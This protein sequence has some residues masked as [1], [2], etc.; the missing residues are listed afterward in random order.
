MLTSSQGRILT[1]G[2]LLQDSIHRRLSRATWLL[3][4]LAPQQ[5]TASSHQQWKLSLQLKL[6]TCQRH[7]MGTRAYRLG[8]R[9]CLLGPRS[10]LLGP[11]A[12]L[13]GLLS[14]TWHKARQLHLQYMHV[15]CN[16]HKDLSSWHNYLLSQLPCMLLRLLCT[17]QELIPRQRPA[18][19][20]S[21]QAYMHNCCVSLHQSKL[22]VQQALSLTSGVLTSTLYL[23]NKPLNGIVSCS[24]MR[25]SACCRGS[26]S[27]SCPC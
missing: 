2:H 16:L 27:F 24:T 7:Y 20:D 21:K 9:S 14:R 19:N 1:C 23:S 3:Q 11:R 18:T 13:L 15:K 5:M 10:W 8:P 4:L 25:S 17:R 22:R 26:V 12:C 6:R